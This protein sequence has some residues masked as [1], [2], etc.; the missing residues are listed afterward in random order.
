MKSNQ[1]STSEKLMH[2]LLVGLPDTVNLVYNVLDLIV[3]RSTLLG[4]AV[5]GAYALLSRHN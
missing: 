3:V 5:M 4:L 1:W 2:N